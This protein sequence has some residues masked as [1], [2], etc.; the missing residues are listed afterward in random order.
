MQLGLAGQSSTEALFELRAEVGRLGEVEVAEEGGRSRGG[1]TE[2]V[3]L[4]EGGE[5]VE[6]G[7]EWRSRSRV[8]VLQGALPGT[9]EGEV[10]G[11]GTYHRRGNIDAVFLPG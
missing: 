9:L 5:G 3:R 11:K 4:E 6:V 10:G 8:D 7:A 2:E 1:G